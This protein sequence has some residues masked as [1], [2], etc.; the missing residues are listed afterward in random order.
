SIG[1]AG[2]GTTNH[3]AILQLQRAF[4][5]EF[6]VVPYNGSAPALNDLLGGQI[7][8]IIDQLPSS[9]A[10]INSRKLRALAVTSSKRAKDLP[11]MRTLAEAGAEGFEVV[12][13]A[14]L[15]VPAG[16]AAT[17]VNTL[18]D[19]LNKALNAPEVKERLAKMG[20]EALPTTPSEFGEFLQG[21]VA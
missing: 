4:D 19:A 7:D 2:N 20:S 8:A 5:V 10:H 1:H 9:I 17:T 21:E 13:A 3:I 15:L 6:N 16:A 18:N 11:E 12:T 14:G